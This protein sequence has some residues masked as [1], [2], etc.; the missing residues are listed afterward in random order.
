MVVEARNALEFARVCAALAPRTGSRRDLNIL[1]VCLLVP[2]LLIYGALLLAVFHVIGSSDHDQNALDLASLFFGA[3]VPYWAM[4]IRTP[5]GRENHEAR[6]PILLCIGLVAV[7]HMVGTGVAW[8]ALPDQPIQAALVG[9]VIGLIVVLTMLVGRLLWPAW[10][11]NELGR[12]LG[13][14]LPLWGARPIREIVEQRLRSAI[15]DVRQSMPVQIGWTEFLQ[16]RREDAGGVIQ[17]EGRRIDIQW[18][19]LSPVLGRTSILPPAQAIAGFAITEM[20]EAALPEVVKAAVAV[21]RLADA[22]SVF[23]GVA[24]VL[25]AGAP[26]AFPIVTALPDPAS[27]TVRYSAVFDWLGYRGPL[28][29]LIEILPIRAAEVLLARY[30]RRVP[31][32]GRRT[33]AIQAMGTQRFMTAVRARPVQGDR[34]GRLYLVGRPEDPSAFVE[35][36]DATVSQ[37]GIRQRY[38]CAVPPHMATAHEAVAWTF[39]RT[40][41]TYEPSVET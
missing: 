41:G 19:E 31:D 12:S 10:W 3:A 38:W 20:D 27:R 4:V 30:I 34:F 32:A 25:S 33:A 40:L 6:L 11:R 5:V 28:S 29:L 39:A 26:I 8:A 1:G 37:D 17:H 15:D 21:D 23:D 9:V 16:S 24:V 35:V 2:T 13:T 18:H 22:I 7:V 36:M 14:R